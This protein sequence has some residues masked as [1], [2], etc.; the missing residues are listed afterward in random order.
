[1]SR[2]FRA[3]LHDC[4]DTLVLDLELPLLARLARKLKAQDA[5]TD[6]DVFASH[7]APD[8]SSDPY[9]SRFAMT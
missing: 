3:S 2:D 8:N 5:A 1:M 9:F 4:G 6:R 7:R